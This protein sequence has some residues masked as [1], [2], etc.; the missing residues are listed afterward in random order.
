MFSFS[1]CIFCYFFYTFSRTIQVCSSF[2][3][4]MQPTA[5]S[6]VNAEKVTESQHLGA[7]SSRT[8]RREL[9]TQKNQKEQKGTAKCSKMQQKTNITVKLSGQSE[10]NRGSAQDTQDFQDRPRTGQKLTQ[11][12]T[13]LGIG[14]RRRLREK[15]WC[16]C[17]VMVFVHM[18]YSQLSPCGPLRSVKKRQVVLLT[19][20]GR[21]RLRVCMCMNLS[22][23]RCLRYLVVFFLSATTEL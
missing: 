5:V 13:Q 16:S 2:R 19:L 15:M 17:G 22:R 21:S 14:K 6:P 7:W 9:S 18:Q 4:V 12:G 8:W 11:T 20:N 10:T 23:V 1:F 3:L